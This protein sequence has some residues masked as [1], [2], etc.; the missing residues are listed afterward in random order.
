V[1]RQR[2][3]NA[4]RAR[5]T[6]R[7]ATISESEKSPYRTAAGAMPSAAHTSLFTPGRF[8]WKRPGRVVDPALTGGPFRVLEY[9]P[10]TWGPG[11]LQEDVVKRRRPRGI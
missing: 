6:D 4:W 11:G 5:G 8:A 9:E 3:T 2:R 1:K 10:G 7:P